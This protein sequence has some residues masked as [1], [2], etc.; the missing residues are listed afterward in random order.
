MKKATV[1][2]IGLGIL[3]A[4]CATDAQVYQ[5][6]DD[7]SASESADYHD[8]AH[9]EDSAGYDCPLPTLS[10]I[11]D[12]ICAG[13]YSYQD[14]QNYFGHTAP[15]IIV[16][17]VATIDLTD[18]DITFLVTPRD[19]ANTTS[20]FLHRYDLDV[21]INGDAFYDGKPVSW[22]I[23]DNDLYAIPNEDNLYLPSRSCLFISSEDNRTPYMV[24]YPLDELPNGEQRTQ[25]LKDLVGEDLIINTKE[26]RKNLESAFSQGICG[27]GSLL[28]E[29]EV[30][31]WLYSRTNPIWTEAHPRTAVGLTD[32]TLYFIVVDGRQL[33]YSM[34]VT[35][36][37]LAQLLQDMGIEDA[38]FLDGGGS[39]TL[40]AKGYGVLNRP[41]D[42]T[43]RVVG[44]H[45]GVKSSDE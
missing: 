22:S 26:K 16:T 20:G 41:S 34:G 4:G 15:R 24:P 6:G 8:E 27:K 35:P 31:P 43:E 13:A 25:E 21:A 2:L 18:Q 39:S 38:I 37:E 19:E 12:G 40:A 7:A 32:S 45:L 36:L 14:L 1:A 9:I 3:A 30:H 44:N 11:R 28:V 23:S 5:P 17:S 42:G 33:G 10:L 29:G